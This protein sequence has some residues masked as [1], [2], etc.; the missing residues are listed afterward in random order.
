MFEEQIGKTMEVYVDDMLTKSLKAC[1]H[2]ADLEKTFDVMD[3]YRM[4]LNPAKCV[5]RVGAGK[6]LGFIVNQRG[7]EA[8]PEK[9][10]ALL[11]MKTPR[12]IKD[13]Q[14]LTGRVAALNIFISRATDKCLPFFKVRRKAF[15]WDKE[16]DEAFDQLKSYLGSPLIL[17]RPIAGERLFVY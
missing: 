6:F 16:C 9:I 15:E 10:K 5:F 4:K 12:S 17:S 11:D 7:I 1:T 13:V 3:S 14:R 8:N 2:V